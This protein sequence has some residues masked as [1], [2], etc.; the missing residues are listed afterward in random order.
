MAGSSPLT[1]I[2]SS[3]IQELD[4][5]SRN[6]AAQMKAEVV[7]PED[8]VNKQHY[9]DY[10]DR[11]WDDPQFRHDLHQQVGDQHL[12][13]IAKDVLSRR[14]TASANI[15]QPPLVGAAAQSVGQIAA[16]TPPPPPP[17]MAPPPIPMPPPPVAPIVAPPPPMTQQPAPAI[18]GLPPGVPLPAIMPH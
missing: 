2:T 6:I 8:V 12:I 7:D 10:V 9:L 4:D 3:I 1:R 11:Q 15:N 18:P 17:P 5:S 13:S 16:L 14:A